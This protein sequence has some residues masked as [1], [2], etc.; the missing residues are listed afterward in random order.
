MLTKIWQSPIQLGLPFPAHQRSDVIDLSRSI[1]C[2]FAREFAGF[3]G[4]DPI[5]REL[6]FPYPDSPRVLD[7][8]AHKNKPE[9]IWTDRCPLKRNKSKPRIV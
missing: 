1:E 5:Q 9:E 7:L 3:I 4:F 6:L 8:R 2:I